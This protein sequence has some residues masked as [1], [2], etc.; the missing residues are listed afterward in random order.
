MKLK[1]LG[2]SDIEVTELTFGCMSIVNDINCDNQNEKDSI[3]AIELSIAEGI[4]FFDT[5]PMYGDGASEVLL[6]K[7]LGTSRKKVVLAS[8]IHGPLKKADVLRECEKS[9]T[10]LNT[11]YIDLYQIHWPDWNTPLEETIAA[12]EQLK[13]DGKIR[14][15]GVSNFG[16]QDLSEAIRLGNV[17]TNQMSYNLIWRNIEKEVQPICQKAGIGILC[18]SSMMQGLLTGKFKDVADVPEGRAR[19]RHFSKNNRPLV[20][21]QE[22]GFEKETFD[23]I[24]AL[25]KICETHHLP[26]G[27]LALK[28]LLAQPAVTSVLAGARNA[29]QAKENIDAVNSEVSTEILK[30]ASEATEHLKNVS[31]FNLDMWAPGSRIR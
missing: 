16:K 3:Q 25:R 6:G 18:Y 1:K 29:Q 23:A 30:E 7:A 13:T 14:L 8:K 15:Y 12:L 2:Q 4:N 27:T 26:M 9:L 21:H 11:D 24:D 10:R 20:R 5:A 31:G 28:W 22:N 19:S 17:V